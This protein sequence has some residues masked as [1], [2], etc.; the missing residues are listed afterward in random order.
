MKIF[1]SHSHQDDAFTRQLVEDLR[2]AGATVWVDVADAGA[3]DFQERI[4]AALDACA[5]AVL[6]LTKSSIASPWVRQEINAA[7][8]LKHQ[9]RIQDVI[10]IKAGPVDHSE[11]P[12]LWGVFNIFDATHDYVAGRNELLKAVGLAPL[13][14]TGTST[15]PSSGG[16]A[17]TESL[18][19]L[20]AQGK[21]LVAQKKHAE[22]LL[23]F[24]RAVRLDPTSFDA[25]N[26]RGNALYDQKRYAE[27]LAPYERATTLKPDNAIFWSNRGG[28]LNG[29]KRYDDALAAIERALTLNPN[30]ANAWN[31]KGLVLSNLNRSD[32]SPEAYD[33]AL[34]INPKFYIAYQNKATALNTL[35]RYEEA[36]T[37]ADQAIS[38]DTNRPGGW[39]RR[40]TALRGL[41]RNAEAAEAERR[42][43]ELGG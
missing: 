24:E 3:G 23:L 17:S 16:S 12:P 18:A 42:A 15:A 1:V 34:A 35:K 40:A 19:D 8:R 21:A 36:L 14:D 6:V 30:Y 27:A 43:K 22:A 33:C 2:S 9:G 38:L 20:L 37:V 10:P 7:I 11:I 41:G 26:L 28:A 13:L 4:N 29:L 5:W 39:Q 31:L 32:E 25:W